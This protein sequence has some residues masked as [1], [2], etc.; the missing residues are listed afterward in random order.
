MV[1]Y[2]NQIKL[3]ANDVLDIIV[4]I[5]WTTLHVSLLSI[6]NIDW[7]KQMKKHD[8]SHITSMSRLL[9]LNSLV[10]VVDVFSVHWVYRAAVAERHSIEIETGIFRSS[11]S[12]PALCNL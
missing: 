4:W 1:K 6:L 12:D 5:L 9:M 2:Y 7:D 3:K 10:F 8:S 11:S